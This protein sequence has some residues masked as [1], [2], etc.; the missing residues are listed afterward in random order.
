MQLFL[1]GVLFLVMIYILFEP[2]ARRKVRQEKHI[3]ED[4]YPYGHFMTR[5]ERKDAGYSD[6][7]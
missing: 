3:V 2:T 5:E 7:E 4:K 1:L 6:E